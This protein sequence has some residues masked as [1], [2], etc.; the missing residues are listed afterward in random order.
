MPAT[1]LGL[2]SEERTMFVVE[3]YKALREE[4][5]TAIRAQ[6]DVL[7]FGTAVLVV[8]LSTAGAAVKERP[9]PAAIAFL[10]APAVSAMTLTMWSAEMFRM[11][12]AA[13]Y[14]HALEDNLRTLAN[15]EVVL[16]WEHKAHRKED[17]DVEATH[18]WTIRI[19]FALVSF[20]SLGFGEYLLWH[21]E[22][23][24]DS[25]VRIVLTAGAVA[26]TLASMGVL[27]KMAYDRHKLCRPYRTAK[28]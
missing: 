2:S 14:I 24:A 21:G 7:R 4:I 23:H 20:A 28:W 10:F 16:G 22:A 15:E 13:V 12:R 8:L 3:E 11:M 6:L 19:G 9:L 1:T 27:A 26:A 17:P 18:T 5:L 25:A